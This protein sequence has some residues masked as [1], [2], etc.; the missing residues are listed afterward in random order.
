MNI[1]TQTKIA[2]VQVSNTPDTSIMDGLTE[3][4]IGSP[5]VYQSIGVLFTGHPLE[6][7]GCT[8]R[9]FWHANVGYM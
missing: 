7:I 9:C 3:S 2:K 8:N 6:V 5:I 1:E 4:I